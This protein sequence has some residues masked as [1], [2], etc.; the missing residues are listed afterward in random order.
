MAIS[1]AFFDSLWSTY[2]KR[3][4]TFTKVTSL[5]VSLQH[6]LFYVLLAFGRFNLYANAYGFLIRTA[7]DPR[8]ARGGRWS[9]WLEV[10]GVIFFWCWFGALLRGCGSWS[11]ALT[12][13]LVSHVITSPLHVQACLL[14]ISL[15]PLFA[16]ASRHRSCS[17]ISPCPPMTLDRSS[18]SPIAN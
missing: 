12:Y 3:S 6:K 15:Y 17:H 18:H 9:W 11:K 1:M 13:L 4:M 5:L 2:Y 7:F 10:V 16:D 8:K 14:C